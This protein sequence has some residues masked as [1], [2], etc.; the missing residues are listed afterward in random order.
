MK[1]FYL[2]KNVIKFV[3]YEVVGPDLVTNFEQLAQ[4]FKNSPMAN[5][6]TKSDHEN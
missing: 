4:N 5:N 6:I 3:G 2:N 1:I